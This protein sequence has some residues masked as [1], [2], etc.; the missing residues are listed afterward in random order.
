MRFLFINHI[1]N[2]RQSLRSNRMRSNLTMLGVMIGV[3]SITT[4][5]SLS[6]GASKIVSNQVDALG[7]NIA[8]VR[9]G[10]ASDTAF[11]NLAQL[12]TPQLFAASTL[13]IKDV[14]AIKKVNYVSG[15]AP[16]MILSGA[17]K[18]ETSTS[19]NTSIIATTPTLADVSGLKIQNGQFLDPDLSPYIA[20]IGPQLSVNVFGTEESI[21]KTLTIKGQAFTVIGVLK[22]QNTPIN[23]NGV[24]FDESI[25]INQDAGQALNQGSLQIQQINVKTD[26]VNNLA[27]AIVDINKAILKNHLGEADF[28]ILSGEQIAQPTNRLFAA[29]AGT[30]TAVAAISLLVG[31]IGIMN[32]MLVSVAER[33]REIGI[34]KA[35]GAS[36]RDI[37]AQFLIESVALSIGGGVGGYIIGYL[38]A[39]AI[40]S[41]LPFFPIFTWE[42]GGIAIGVSLVIGTLFGL[43]PAIRAARKDPIDALR[44]YD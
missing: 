26:S 12:P 8:V 6:G 3:A 35:L 38:I 44:Q 7:G 14:N 42:I 31:G 27:G 29:I 37:V 9:P 30:T 17:V 16:M 19:V 10:S 36:N 22:R 15:V 32:I 2:A 39:F 28:T 4:I 34:R 33:T 25:I 24:D 13:T 41:F 11:Q 21:G 40:S 43:Y 23:Y 20:V 1:Q 18:A 5:L